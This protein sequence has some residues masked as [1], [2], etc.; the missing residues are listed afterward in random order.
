MW[1]AILAIVFVTNNGA[2]AP[3]HVVALPMQS[4]AMCEQLV[5]TFRDA[6]KQSNPRDIVIAHC[7]KVP[8]KANA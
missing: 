5:T 8:P 1:H 7:Q 4:K 2:L 3:S 6:A